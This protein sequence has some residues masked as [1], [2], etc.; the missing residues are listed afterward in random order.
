LYHASQLSGP[1]PMGPSGR[2]P[3]PDRR[4]FRLLFRP[5]FFGPLVRFRF[6]M[7]LRTRRFTVLIL[8]TVAI[9]KYYVVRALSLAP[10]PLPPASFFRSLSRFRFCM[11]LRNKTLHS[12]DPYNC[13]D[14]KIL[15]PASP[16]LGAGPLPF[17]SVRGAAEC[18]RL[19]LLIRLLLFWCNPSTS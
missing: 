10:R 19:I 1:E 12:F 13:R 16:R 14:W 4:T 9:G 8:T 6:C 17:A 5:Y 18:P 2:V 11:L 3:I 7:L 15:C